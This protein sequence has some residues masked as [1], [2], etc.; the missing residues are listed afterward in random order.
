MSL[1]VLFRLFTP[2]SRF[3][4]ALFL[5]A[6][7]TLGNR[8]GDRPANW[9][10]TQGFQERSAAERPEAQYPFLRLALRGISYPHSPSDTEAVARLCPP[11]LCQ[12]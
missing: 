3:F 1:V 4:R 5:P 2:D 12:A 10:R 11:S 6:L 7:S 9:P 8:S